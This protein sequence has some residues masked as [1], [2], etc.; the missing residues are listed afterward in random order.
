MGY[1]TDSTV[2]PLP[3]LSTDVKQLIDRFFSL[4]DNK[5]SDSGERLAR[6]VFTED[7]KFFA[8]SGDFEGSAGMKHNIGNLRRA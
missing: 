1:S 3:H 4:V 8:T 6:E 5:G 7:G 2:W